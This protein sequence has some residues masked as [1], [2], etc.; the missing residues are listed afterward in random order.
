MEGLSSYLWDNQQAALGMRSSPCWNEIT[1]RLEIMMTNKKNIA[2]T[3]MTME[4][5]MTM[6]TMAMTTTCRH[7]LQR[8]QQLLEILKFDF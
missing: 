7:M 1:I 3:T 8:T 5:K 6:M 2:M 4:M